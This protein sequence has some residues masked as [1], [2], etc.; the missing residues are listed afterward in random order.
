VQRRGGTYVVHHEEVVFPGGD[1]Q[2]AEVQAPAERGAPHVQSA[3]LAQRD[4]RLPRAPRPETHAKLGRRHDQ[5]RAPQPAQRPRDRGETQGEGPGRDAHVGRRGQIVVSDD[6]RADEPNEHGQAEGAGAA[7]RMQTGAEE[8]SVGRG[9]ALAPGAHPFGICRKAHPSA[10]GAD[11]PSRRRPAIDAGGH[12]EATMKVGARASR[13]EDGPMGR[14]DVEALAVNCI[15]FLAADAVER[16]NSGHPGLPLGAAPMAYALWT[17]HLRHNPRNPR[18]PNRD[19]FVLSAGHGSMLLYALLHLTGYDVTID[20]LREFRQWNSRAPGHPEAHLTPGVEATTGPLG[21]GFAMGVG[22]ALAEAH[23]AA[24]FNRAGQ[25]VVDHRTYVLASDGDLMEGVA[26]EAASLAGHLRLGK[27]IV[28]YDANAVCLAGATALGFSE[29][30]AARFRAYGWGVSAVPDG[31][32]VAAVDRAIAAAKAD[33]ARPSLIV[34]HTRIGFGAPT[35]EGSFAAHGAP[36]GADELRAAKERL[37]WPAEP[38]LWVPPDVE[39]HL[40]AAVGRGSILEADWNAR[41]DAYRSACPDDAAELERRFTGT[42]GAGWD[43]E[44]PQFPADAKGMPTRK[45]GEAVLQRLAAGV[46]ELVGG[47]ADLNP[48]TL[49]WVKGG[50]DLE[51]PDFQ[52]ADRQGAV[53]GVWGYA[54]RNVHFGVREHAMGAIVNGM[55][56]HGG[57]LPY[58]STFLVFSDYMRPAIRLSALMGIGSVWIYT[59]DSVAVGEDGPTHQPVE[60]VMSLRAVPDLLVIRPADANETAWAWR[61]A[62]AE[63]RRPTAL[64]LTRQNVPTLDRTALAPAEGLRRGAY[65]LNP[66]VEP[67]TGILMAT[68]SEVALIVAAEALLRARGVAVRLVSMPCWELFEEQPAA[69]REAVLPSAITAR[70]AVEAGVSLGWS[71]YT[72]ARGATIG[73]DRFG[74]SA[75]GER[76]YRELGFTPEAVAERLLAVLA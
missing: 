76:V 31:N 59:H 64:I 56:L 69:Y 54:G 7:H 2:R 19:R 24:R 29:D 10:T 18:W 42:L 53:G 3:N 43:A 21:Q 33:E 20:D 52:P 44:L 47:S 58:G 15:R 12:V 28:L 34:V 35:K 40:R 45:A 37:G 23:L 55:A 70:V 51:P 32:D 65:V 38:S 61:T 6:Q 75:P 73:V 71:R 13:A 41:L 17:R 50:G 46:P 22:F 27:L 5:L 1:R 66:R 72:G 62:V 60:H 68:G 4:V 25:H 30:V 26:A 63:R 8:R 39:G 49:T 14:Q 9:V 74:A 16:A 48:S 11:L 57:I 36:L 67:F